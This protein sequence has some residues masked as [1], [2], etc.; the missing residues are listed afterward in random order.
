M[1]P[2]QVK[3]QVIYGEKYIN[4]FCTAGKVTICHK[5]WVFM[6]YKMQSEC[7][8][9]KK[10]TY[11]LIAGNLPVILEQYKYTLSSCNYRCPKILCP[12]PMSEACARGIG[13]NQLF[14]H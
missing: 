5:V 10:I 13:V 6:T 12:T 2:V 4:G 14:Q 3:K 7:W 11:V 1:L 8:E 9:T